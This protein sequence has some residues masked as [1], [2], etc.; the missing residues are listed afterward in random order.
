MNINKKKKITALVTAVGG[1]SV[2]YQILE[3]LKKYPKNY[4]L[5]ATDSGPFAPGL[6]ESSKGYILPSSLAA[7]YIPTLIKICKKEKVDVV[8][9]GSIPEILVIAK[10]ENELLKNN[11]VPIT[12]S[13]SLVKETYDKL[14][15]Y[16]LLKKNNL[17]TPETN[18]L[19]DLSDL[20]RLGYPLIVKPRGG[21]SGSRNVHIL[22]N[23]EELVDI[24]IKLKR[25]G[26]NLLAQEYVGD[27]NEEYTVGVLCGNDGRV[28]DTIVMRRR[29]IGLSRGEERKIDGK[30][31]VLS[32]GY[33]QGFFVDQP[34]VKKYCELAAKKLGA[35][36]PFNIQC[37]RGK[38]GVYIFEVHPR[39]SG[40]ASM[41]AEMGFNEPH[42]LIRDFLG[43][44]HVDKVSHK[45]SYAVI[46]KFANT[47]VSIKKYNQLG[48]TL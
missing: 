9:P 43:I 46:R 40:S 6:Y 48:K 33:S 14:D 38:K 18:E 15:V 35:R 17:L 20:N 4:R 13:Y 8:L 10:Y 22:K 28:I 37:R 30:N 19:K 11:I 25:E 41:R 12:N 44:Q 31:Y 34:D 26:I 42:I 45:V 3:C 29:L 2:G 39:F 1:R 47:V 7:K 21:S 16:K 23:K 24:F 36:G 5:I 27:E 32:T